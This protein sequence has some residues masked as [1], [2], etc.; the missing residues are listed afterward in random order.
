MP[1]ARKYRISAAVIGVGI[2]AASSSAATAAVVQNNT[3]SGCYST[4]SGALRVIDTAA[5]GCAKGETSISWNQTGPQGPAGE[6]GPHGDKGDAGSVGAPGPAGAMGLPG[7]EGPIGPPGPQ[8]PTGSLD[9]IG[10]NTGTGTGGSSGE[11]CTLGEITLSAA[12]VGR[13]TPAKGQVLPISQNFALFSLLGDT[14]G[15]DG[16]STF[17][18]PDLQSLA[19]NNM[20]YYICIQGYFPSRQ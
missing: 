18:L 6:A 5:H 17:A 16:L 9:G 14:Y 20:T 11:S 3:I 7:P 15:G 10:T 13:G 1:S 19:P 12:S 8:G 4:K 2:I